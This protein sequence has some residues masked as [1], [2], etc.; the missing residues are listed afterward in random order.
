MA[1]HNPRPPAELDVV[2]GLSE[3]LSAAP[4]ARRTRTSDENQQQPRR[5]NRERTSTVVY[6]DGQPVLTKNNY[7]LK[8]M[9]Y[10][11]RTTS[12]ASCMW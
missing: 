2:V 11:Y 7:V 5:T 8:G 6:I 12:W 9:S 3:D 4:A 1:D 10:E